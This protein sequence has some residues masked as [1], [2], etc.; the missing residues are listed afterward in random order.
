[1]KY[2]TKFETETEYNAYI[3]GSDVFLPNVSLIGTTDVRYNPIP[4]ATNWIKLSGLNDGD[5]VEV[6]SGYDPSDLTNN[7][8]IL[9]DSNGDV[10]E[11]VD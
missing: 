11:V 10:M 2:L 3:S 5:T 9:Y 7:P 1:M 8:P 6:G 4:P